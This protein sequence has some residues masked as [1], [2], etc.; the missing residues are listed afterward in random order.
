MWQRSSR[1]SRAPFCLRI[2][3]QFLNS[4]QGRSG[5]QNIQ[6]TD[7]YLCYRR[8]HEPIHPGPTPDPS[9]A[10]GIDA[11]RVARRRGR[12]PHRRGLRSGDDARGRRT[13]RGLP[14]GATAL[15]RWTVRLG[16][17][18]PSTGVAA[19]RRAVR[20][21]VRTGQRDERRRM[22][23]LLDRC[24]MS[25]TVP[26]SRPRLNS[27]PPPAPIPNCGSRSK[28]SVGTS[29]AKLAQTFAEVLPTLANKDAGRTLLDVNDGHRP[30]SGMRR[31][32]GLEATVDRRWRA[33]KSLLMDTGAHPRR[34][35]GM[36]T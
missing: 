3:E 32:P 17:P 9:R 11:Y 7:L 4:R 12:V 20:S 33:A 29:I 26:H 35:E 30:R 22:Q 36:T 27:G 23:T 6:S 13:C 18:R 14:R 5:P 28:I 1:V 16:R 21:T 24:W 10:Q 2:S 34:Q 31:L 19:I 8:R 25:T 15:L